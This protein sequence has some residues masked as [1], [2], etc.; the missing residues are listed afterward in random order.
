V[1]NLPFKPDEKLVEII[2]AAN[3]QR[4]KNW[5]SK[6]SNTIRQLESPFP[7]ILSGTPLENRLGELFTV[8]RFADENLL[9]PA[10]QFFHKYHVVDERGK[11]LGYRRLEELRGTLKPR[12]A[13]RICK[14]SH[15]FSR[16]S[17]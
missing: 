8:A 9:G 6:T 14:R 7:L 5:E 13:S 12:F 17:S 4:I 3:G 15:R 11:T 2:D 16:R 1:F 10:Y